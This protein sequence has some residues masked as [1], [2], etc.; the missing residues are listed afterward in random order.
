MLFVFANNR[1]YIL[2][3]Q[4]TQVFNFN[5]KLYHIYLNLSMYFFVYLLIT[6]VLQKL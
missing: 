2:V 5:L 3:I 1:D 6:K 4:I